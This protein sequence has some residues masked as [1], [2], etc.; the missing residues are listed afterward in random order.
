[1]IDS[2]SQ[3]I[4]LETIVPPLFGGPR[5][6]TGF[7]ISELTAPS[8]HGSSLTAPSNCHFKIIIFDYLI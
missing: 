1:M 3:G 7:A 6:T 4:D 2:L 8:F 5:R